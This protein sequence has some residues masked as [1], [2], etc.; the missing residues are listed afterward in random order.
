ML[1]AGCLWGCLWTGG[2]HHSIWPSN[3]HFLDR[4]DT[5][6]SKHTALHLPPAWRGMSVRGP[7]QTFRGFSQPENS[8]ATLFPVFFFFS[9]LGFK[10]RALHLLGRCCT[11]QAMPWSFLN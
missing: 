10:L 7:S 9:S 2:C 6:P 4:D 1:S 8:L 3:A 11:T 5:R